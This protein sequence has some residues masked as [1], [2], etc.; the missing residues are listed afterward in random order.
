[1]KFELYYNSAQETAIHY[2]V[3]GGHISTVKL[4]IDWNCD[5]TIVGKFGTP[6]DVA[7]STKQEPIIRIL[8]G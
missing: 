4:L 2:A 1:M 8:E 3:R 7:I 6:L 5:L